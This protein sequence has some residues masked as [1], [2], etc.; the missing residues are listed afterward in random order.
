MLREARE[1]RGVSL[2]E[3]ANTT[4]IAL[5]VLEALERNDIS[6]LPGGIFGRGFVRSYALGVGLDPET[7]IQAFI[8]Q[9]PHDSVTV[10]HPTTQQHEDNDAIES[11]RRTAT[12]FMWL[13]GVSVLILGVLL[14]FSTVGRPMPSP[15]PGGTVA[16]GPPSSSSASAASAPPALGVPLDA[17]GAVDRLTVVLSAT[18]ACVVSVTADG[19]KVVDDRL[20]PGDGRTLEV[21]RELLLT[22][23]DGEA[24]TMTLNGLVARPLGKTGEPVAL[25]LD[26]INFRN[27]L[28]PR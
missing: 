23:N 28:L 7:A 11:D 10:G 13:V 5:R 2:R 9:F 8:A 16:A 26:L 19:A 15:A 3:L 20:A 17:A 25:R 24:I 18:R 21:R 14:Y 27:Y 6:H 4:K 12:T 22:V 1:R